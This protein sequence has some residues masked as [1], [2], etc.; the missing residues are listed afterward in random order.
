MG[1]RR[2]L[3]VLLLLVFLGSGRATADTIETEDGDRLKG[4]V[5]RE[6][7]GQIV[8]RTPSYGELT[9]LRSA[10]KQH[11]RTTYL[12]DLKNGSTLEGQIVAQDGKTLTLKVGK[13]TRPLPLGDV[14]KVI[15]K[16][17]PPPPPPTPAKPDPQKLLQLHQRTD[18]Q[19]A[20]K[21]YSGARATCE[22]ILRSDPDDEGAIYNL[23]CAWARLGDK[24]KALEYL[25]KSVE[26]GFVDFPHIEKDND[27]DTLRA[28][29]PYRDLLAKRTEYLQQSRAKIAARLTKS[30]AERGIDAKRYKTEFDAERNFVYLHAKDDKEMAEFRRGLNAYADSQWR[31]LFRNR[32]Q[33]PLYIV[34]LTAA[35]SPKVFQGIVGGFYNSATATLFCSDMPVNRLLRA[36]VVIHEFTHA[37][38]F[39]DMAARRQEH[40]IWL[41]EGLATLF[42]SSDQNGKVVPRQNHRLAALHPAAQQ[43]SLLPWKTL[44]NLTPAQFMA[45]PQLAYAQ[46]RYVL[47]YLYDKGLLK[48]FY[49]EYAADANYAHDRTGI[50]AMQAVFGKLIEE[51]ERDWRRWLPKQAVPA[52]PFLG[53]NTREDNK[54][55]VV[56]EVTKGSPADKAGIRVGDTIV[57]IAGQAIQ[58][59]AQLM[60]AVGS[61]RVDEDAL[62]DLLRDGKTVS[63]V[64]KLTRRTDLTPHI[65]A[66]PPYL[67]LTVEQKDG[68]VAIKEVDPKSPA[69]RAGFKPGA[70]ILNFGGKR[71]A[72]VREFLA[73]LRALRPGQKVTIEAKL[74]DKAQTATVDLAPQP[75]TD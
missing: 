49:D 16:P 12:V 5:V 13:D 11:T 20:K 51:V 47:F 37:L 68:A 34:L 26:A 46:A 45:Q 2:N 64:P 7:P 42:E 14:K 43:G 56:T 69:E 31:D 38:Q 59:Q 25:R 33:R 58:S 21:D 48:R 40:P 18:Q 75:G 24:P 60:D 54:H 19:F 55:V 35:D 53:V 30:L 9:I 72:S 22:E 67:G 17:P 74:G 62:V 50:E 32:P 73:A 28:E 23:A 52:V 57:S 70:A 29:Q 6:E 10:I 36:D 66:A 39:A 27:L 61:R 3:G 4:R 8:L 65:P 71:P 41:V 15:E 1:H 44:M 63:V